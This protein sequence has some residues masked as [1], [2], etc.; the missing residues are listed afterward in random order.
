MEPSG[1]ITAGRN[2]AGAPKGPGIACGSNGGA[3]AWKAE[4][5]TLAIETGGCDAV[6]KEAGG[7]DVVACVGTDAKGG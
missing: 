3:A 7:M 4:G 5:C 2:G 6:A 1:F